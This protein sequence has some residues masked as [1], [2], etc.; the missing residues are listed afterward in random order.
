[1]RFIVSESLPGT[2]AGNE[3]MIQALNF[4]KQLEVE[5]V[6]LGTFAGLNSA[7]HLYQ[8]FGFKI[9]DEFAGTQW[10]EYVTEQRY[11]LLL[12]S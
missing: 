5:N 7:K 6:Y 12:R 11:Q 3:L 8:K 4:C 10:G 1:M 9:I 2:G